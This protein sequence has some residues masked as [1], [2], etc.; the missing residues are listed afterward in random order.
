MA[1]SGFGALDHVLFE[2]LLEL[3]GGR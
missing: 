3:L 1:L 2:R